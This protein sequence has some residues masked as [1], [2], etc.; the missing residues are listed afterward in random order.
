MEEEKNTVTLNSDTKRA[1]SV[2]KYL[3]INN[4]EISSTLVVSGVGFQHINP[5]DEYPEKGHPVGYT[6]DP[7]IG[8]TLDDY[9]LVYI[10]R[11]EGSLNTFGSGQKKIAQGDVFFIRRGEWHTYCPDK[12][13]G[14]DEY[15]VTFKG[16]Y[17][18]WL[19]KSFVDEKNPIIYI[20]FDDRIVQLLQD[21]M[22]YAEM[23]QIGFQQILSGSV[24]LVFGLVNSISRNQTFESQ[25]LQRIKEACVM[26]RENILDKLSATD[27]AS[28]L[29]MSYSNFRKLFKQYTGMSP[30]QYMLQLRIEK[31]KDLLG[32]TDMSVQDI[33]DNLN[34]ESADYFSFFFRSKTGINPRLY[35]QR[36]E[37]QR[38]AARRNML[39]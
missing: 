15:W 37:K 20:G 25:E 36:I 26:M 11:G 33:A 17:F 24:L 14:W 23:Q 19:Y 39:K 32:S 5:G 8:R 30:H 9:A 35:R 4:D 10:T 22:K 7:E 28:S 18:D 16:S 34:F 31:I 3:S 2:L 1:H 6:F 21:I 13:I 12:K 27:I 29:N 38:V